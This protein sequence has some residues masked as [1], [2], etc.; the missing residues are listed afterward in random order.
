MWWHTNAILAACKAE[1]GALYIQDPKQFRETL[2][3]NFKKVESLEC[4][5][6]CFIGFNPCYQKNKYMN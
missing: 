5:W 4:V 1:S 3:Q 2:S 6:I